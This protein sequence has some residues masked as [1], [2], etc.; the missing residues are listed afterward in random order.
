MA[1]TYLD[2]LKSV[3]PTPEEL[4]KK[5]R[6]MQAAKEKEIKEGAK[7]EIAQAQERIQ[8]LRT[9]PNS[10]YNRPWDPEDCED[11]IQ[12][13]EEVQDPKEEFQCMVH[14]VAEILMKNAEDESE[15]VR[16]YTD[17][18]HRLQKLKKCCVKAIKHFSKKLMAS[19]GP[20]SRPGKKSPAEIQSMVD[21]HQKVHDW[22]VTEITKTQEK[23]SDELAHN[24]AL[25]AE[26]IEFTGIKLAPDDAKEAA[27]VIGDTSK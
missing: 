1:Q 12:K 17:Q 14:S 23:I 22:T 26:Y 3:G 9:N 18:I 15:A 13:Y 21:Y 2:L 19:E 25:I 16:G 20:E 10:T 5:Q 24:S 7:Q 6:E 8:E 27:K 11:H 4:A